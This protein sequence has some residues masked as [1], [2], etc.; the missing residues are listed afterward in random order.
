MK[1]KKSLIILGSSITF[2]LISSIFFYKYVTMGDEIPIKKI[3]NHKNIQAIIDIKIVKI[4]T[5]ND[6]LDRLVPSDI[7]IVKE[8]FASEVKSI[9]NGIHEQSNYQIRDENGNYY[10]FMDSDI[11]LLNSYLVGDKLYLNLSSNITKS[12]QTKEQELLIIY[13][14]VNTYTSLE[15]INRVKILIDDVEVNRLKWYSLKTFYTKNLD[16]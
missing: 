4:Y 6:S 3:T 1:D 12:I 9:F 5:P 7:E 2:L 11:T 10:P 13:S 15:G 14:L 16:I 8:D